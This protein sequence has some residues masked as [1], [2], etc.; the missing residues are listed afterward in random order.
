MV[1]DEPMF[2]ASP[3]YDVPL[4]DEDERC[5]VQYHF[6][7]R[8]G[9]SL[10]RRQLEHG[11]RTLGWRTLRLDGRGRYAGMYEVYSLPWE[12]FT[13]DASGIVR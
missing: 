3:E 7:E 8:I 6:I 11:L 9:S 2:Y 10:R 12:A 4:R 1:G 13:D 5:D